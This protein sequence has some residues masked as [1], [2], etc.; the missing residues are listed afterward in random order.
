MARP[1]GPT[2]A[3]DHQSEA[4]D[5]NCAGETRARHGDDLKPAVGASQEALR[6]TV[7]V[8]EPSDDCALGVDSEDLCVTPP[9]NRRA[10]TS[11]CSAGASRRRRRARSRSRPSPPGSTPARSDRDREERCETFQSGRSKTGPLR[12]GRSGPASEETRCEG[13]AGP[14]GGPPVRIA[15]GEGCAIR[16]LLPERT[17][18][19][20]QPG[21]KRRSAS[22]RGSALGESSNP[23]RGRPEIPAVLEPFPL[24]TREPARYG[25]WSSNLARKRSSRK[26][27]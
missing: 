1:I 9:G 21:N 13:R 26:A 11:R 12:D 16:N 20:V 2:I 4:V 6:H 14:N 24:E 17:H 18:G 15:P 7:C 3:A 8:V 5:V 27:G 25:G 19:C 10:R 23:I 22:V